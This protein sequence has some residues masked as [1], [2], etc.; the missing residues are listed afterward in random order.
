MNATCSA[1][2]IEEAHLDWVSL[3][4]D[5]DDPKAIL[6]IGHISIFPHH[7]NAPG[8]VWGVEEAHLGWVGL[9]S[10]R[11]DPK[12]STPSGHIG[13]FSHDV[14]APCPVW[15]VEEAH[16]G[17]IGLVSNGDDPK[18][19]PPVSHVS[20]FSYHL[21]VRCL[22]WGVRK[23]HLR[24]VCLVGHRDHAKA[25][26]PSGHVRVVGQDINILYQLWQ[27]VCSA[28]LGGIGR[29]GDI[30]DNQL[31]PHPDVGIV[32]YHVCGVGCPPKLPYQLQR[33]TS[34]GTRR[35]NGRP[36]KGNS[37][38]HEPKAQGSQGNPPQIRP[39][40]F[41]PLSLLELTYICTTTGFPRPAPL[42]SA[43]D[44]RTGPRRPFPKRPAAARR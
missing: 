4:S 36:R 34:L 13:I 40:H 33:H 28:H 37:R 5:R 42:A 25:S 30:Q 6:P 3:V 27:R 1:W 26:L 12:S 23:A 9:V 21:N 41:L 24:R 17:W 14:S 10:K 16:L 39:S 20:I 38:Q 2:R 31:W 8:P 15:R 35:Q 32:P 22:V 44:G 7:V 19:T 29:I 11:D 18:A 43:G